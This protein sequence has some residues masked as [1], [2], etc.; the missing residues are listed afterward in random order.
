MYSDY[1]NYWVSS[2][3]YL[4]VWGR[5]STWF[6]MFLACMITDIT[7]IQEIKRSY[8]DSEKYDLFQAWKWFNF[9]FEF[10]FVLE[11]CITIMFWSVL[12]K[13]DM[14]EGIALVDTLTRLDHC[15]PVVVLLFEFR[16]NSLQ[17]C[18]R[19]FIGSLTI[20]TI[21]MLV[22]MIVTFSDKPVYDV[23]DW[24]SYMG[25]VVVPLGMYVLLFLVYYVVKKIA[26]FKNVRCGLN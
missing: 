4:T 9:M 10:V 25:G 23:I 20:C 11:I 3:K 14:Y 21:Y 2:S 19:H 8:N 15:L 18:M 5:H 12:N 7:S 17:F 24:Q 6:T 13:P 16:L 1:G 22:N 26:F